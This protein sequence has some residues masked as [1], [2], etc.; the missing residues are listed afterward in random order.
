MEAENLY[1]SKFSWFYIVLLFIGVIFFGGML[2]LTLD[3]VENDNALSI[4]IQ[5]LIPFVFFVFCLLCVV[6][7]LKLKSITI[8]KENLKLKYVFL[9]YSYLIPWNEIEDVRLKFSPSS[10]DSRFNET[11][12]KYII[13][14]KS[15]KVVLY[16]QFYKNFKSFTVEL[17]KRLSAEI[18]Q[19]MNTEYKKEKRSILAEE[20]K[21]K[22]QLKYIFGLLIIILI[23]A[24]LIS[25]LS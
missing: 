24:M 13:I 4:S 15:K 21:S 18:K 19:N 20:R 17:N 23:I 2:I 9:G 14:C 11:D 7:I 1:N 5:F 8:T 22:R 6:E 3:F 10:D 12:R 16:S 25:T